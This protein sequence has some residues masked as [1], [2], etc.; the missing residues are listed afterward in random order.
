[1]KLKTKNQVQREKDI[2]DISTMV[3]GNFKLSEVLDKLAEAAVKATNT[4]ACSLRL[5]NDENKELEMRSTYG[6]SEKYR[7]KGVVSRHDPVI[8]AA[9][10]GDAVVIDNMQD[11]NRVKYPQAAM[12]EG[13]VSQLTVSMVFRNTKIGVLRLYSPKP[14]HFDDDT[15]AIARL[16]AAQCAVAISNARLYAKAIEGARM[17]EQMRLAAIVQRRMIPKLAPE[18]T[19]LDVAAV[20]SPCFQ[21][22]GDLYDFIKID[23]NTLVVAIA[24]VIGKGIPAAIM[25][26]MFRGTL[27]AYAD[28]GHH[29]HSMAEIVEKLNKTSFDECDDGEFITL[30]LAVIDTKN[31][32]I[33]Y[34][35]CGHEP[36]MLVRNNKIIELDKGGMVLGVLEDTEYE[37]ATV[38]LANCDHLL[39]YTDGLI[40]AV[41]FDGELWGKERMRQAIEQCIACP[42]AEQMIH[43]LLGYRRRFVGLA[44]QT[45]DTSVVAMRVG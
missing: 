8:K 7:N 2:L 33:K 11:D 37:I 25:M 44:P 39:M 36:A 19:N 23:D 27:R 12:D 30:F 5:L 1:M 28:G 42:A 24:D 4:Q 40:D 45:D 35:N 29:R 3:A 10:E 22:G 32:T 38:D 43:L 20:Y 16:V 31:M 34:C 26:S 6:L 15:V 13:L 41:N 21:I 18:I 9:F 17:E 14:K